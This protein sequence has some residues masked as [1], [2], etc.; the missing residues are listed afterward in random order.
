[1]DSKHQPEGDRQGV[2]GAEKWRQPKALV[3]ETLIEISVLA[4][5][6]AESPAVDELTGMAGLDLHP[7]PASLTTLVEKIRVAKSAGI[8]REISNSY[9]GVILSYAA[10]FFTLPDALYQEFL[11]TVQDTFGATFSILYIY[12]AAKN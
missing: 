12:N 4:K 5:V 1:M 7:F 11:I 10:S 2:S 6:A 9:S 8:V 3:M